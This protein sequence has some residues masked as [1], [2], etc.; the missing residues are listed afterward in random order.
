MEFVDVSSFPKGVKVEPGS[1]IARGT[2]K[3]FL[4]GSHITSVAWVPSGQVGSH[5]T[6]LSLE[7]DDAGA[8]VLRRWTAGHVGK[9]MAIL[10]DGRVVTKPTVMGPIPTGSVTV[11]GRGVIA[12]RSA[13]D[14]ATVSSR[15]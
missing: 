12:M 6:A 10:L 13:I 1:T 15:P 9:E 8:A 3:P 4:T 7:L 2:Y 14:S 11:S 5:E